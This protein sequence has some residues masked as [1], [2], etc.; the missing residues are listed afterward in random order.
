[1]IDVPVDKCYFVRF[2]V[3]LTPVG[4]SSGCCSD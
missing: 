4:C 2:N 1:M 3:A